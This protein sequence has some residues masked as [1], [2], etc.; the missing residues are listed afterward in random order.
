M[1]S[2][3]GGCL[4]MVSSFLFFRFPYSFYPKG[5]LVIFCQKKI[6]RP[7]RGEKRLISFKEDRY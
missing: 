5:S 4:G 1:D 7:D 6:K 2:R 3:K